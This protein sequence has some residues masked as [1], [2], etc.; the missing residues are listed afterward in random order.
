MAEFEKWLDVCLPKFQRVSDSIPSIVKSLLDENNIEY[1]SVTSRTKTLDSISEKVKRKTYRDPKNQLTD[2]SGIRIILFIE[3]DID[4]VEEIIYRSFRVDKK[5]SS[6]REERLSS[7]EVGYRSSHIVCDIGPQRAKLPE[8]QGLEWLKF[9][10]Q[11]RTVLQHAWAEL[12][13]DRSY[14]FQGKLPDGIQ[15]RLYLYA[16]LLE[17]ADKGFSEIA[18]DI[19]EYEKRISEKYEKG[20]LDVEINTLSLEKFVSERA[21]DNSFLVFDNPAREA[22]GELIVELNRF[23]IKT[24]DDLNKIIPKKFSE[25]ADE[26]GYKTNIFGF[27]R[28]L[29]IINDFEKLYHVVKPSWGMPEITIEEE[30]LFKR[31]STKENFNNIMRDYQNIGSD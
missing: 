26:V 14:K 8:F 5:N 12:A 15:R 16:G 20:N 24:I 19:E 22:I 25:V 21:R 23:G 6:G 28:D 10:F 1:L 4:R 29:M 3:S 7:N 31:L 27:I 11:I 2:I 13:H 17:I 30:K 9:E 18:L